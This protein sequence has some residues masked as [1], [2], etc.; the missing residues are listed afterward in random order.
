M[1]GITKTNFGSFGR[2]LLSIALAGF[3]LLGAIDQAFTQDLAGALPQEN[4]DIIGPTR[5]GTWYAGKPTLQQNEVDLVESLVFPGHI[6]AGFNDYR[7]V[8]DPIIGGAWPGIA[9]TID[10][11]IWT[12]GLIPGHLGDN[13]NLGQK[14]GADPNLEIA[15]YI[16]YYNHMAFTRD[17]S[18][19]PTMHIARFYE[20]IREV[21]EPFRFLDH[22]TVATGTTS[23]LYDKPS[24]KLSILDPDRNLPDIQFA[25][26][27]FQDP[28]NPDN[29]HE[30]YMLNVPAHRLHLCMTLFVGNDNNDGTKVECFA[31]DDGGVTF[32]IKNKLSSSIE[33]NQ[34]TSIATRNF[35]KDVTVVWLRFQDH[36]EDAAVMYASSTDY[37]E[38]Y[39]AAREVAKICPFNQTTGAAR[40][41]TNSLP[42]I[43]NSGPNDVAVYVAAR[44]DATETCFNPGKGNKPGE[45]LMSDVMLADDFDDFGE[46][47][48][49]DGNRIKDGMVRTSLNFSRIMMIRGTGSKN[50]SWGTPVAIDPQEDT[51]ESDETVRKR[52][53][54]FMPACAAAQ[55]I[56]TCSFFDTRLDKFNT[57]MQGLPAAPFVEDMVL[58]LE[59]GVPANDP[60]AKVT[61]TLLP[62][63]AYEGVPDPSL[64][65]PIKNNVPLRRTLE[66]FATSVRHGGEIR[67]YTVNKDTFY[68]TDASDPD[69]MR[70]NSVRISQFAT[71][72]K[73]GALAGVREQVEWNYCC[74][75]MFEKGKASFIGDYNGMTARS[76]RQR[77]DLEWVSNEPALDPFT[78]LFASIEPAFRAGWTS[79]HKAR[80]KI[81]YTGCDEWDES[82]QMWVSGTAGCA[83]TYTDPGT[84]LPLQGE[85]GSNDGPPLTCL[86]AYTDGKA[87]APL[88]RNQT[89]MTAAMLPDISARVVS[90]IKPADG[91]RSTFVLQLRN[92]SRSDRTVDLTLPPGE[93]VSFGADAADSILS[94]PVNVPAGSGN[95]RTA[96]DFGDSGA[97]PDLPATVILEVTDAE[98]GEILARVPLL[99]TSLETP[100]LETVQSNPDPE[101]P[102]DVPIDLLAGGE[103]YDL[104]L[105][106][107]IGVDP[108]FAILGGES[109]DLEN[110]PELFDLENLDF[111]SFDLENTL[112]FFDLENFDLENTN[113]EFDLYQAFDL[114]NIVVNL[115]NVG[116][117]PNR[118]LY[119]DLENFELENFDLENFDLENFELENFEL[120]NFELENFD[121]EN[122]ELENESVFASSIQNF[123]LENFEL[124]N[125]AP[126]DEY[127]E[128]SW[129]VDSSGN[130]TTGVDIRPIFSPDVADELATAVF[131]NEST[132]LM[133]VR[134]GY[135]N[136]TVGFANTQSCSAEIIV[137]SQILYAAILSGDQILAAEFNGTVNDPDPL[138]ADTPGFFIPPD[139]SAVITYRVI[140]PPIDINTLNKGS[141]AALFTQP[142]NL[143][144]C[145]AELPGI[146]V[147]HLCEV[148]FT[149]PD[150]TPPV[151]TVSGPS[152][153]T[154]IEDTGPYFHLSAATASDSVDG[155]VSVSVSGWNGDTTQPGTYTIT[156]T[157]TDAALNSSTTT[158]SVTV[159][160]KT[161]PVI[162]LKNP[163]VTA[164][165]AGYTYKDVAGNIY[166]ED[167]LGAT[168][169][170][171]MD[172]VVTVSSDW[173]TVADTATHG[174]S[175]TVTFTAYDNV[176]PVANKAE[177]TRLFTVTDTE[178]PVITPNLVGGLLDVS[179]E[180]GELY[181]D[182]EAIVI[183]SGSPGIVLLTTYKDENGVEISAI[184]TDIAGLYTVHYNAVDAA[185]LTAVEKTRTV[186]VTDSTGPVI[187]SPIPPTFTPTLDLAVV[188]PDANPRTFTISWPIDVK[189]LE[190]ELV[191]S[192]V[193]NGSQPPILP[194]QALSEYNS[195]T[196]IMESVF[197][198]DDFPVGT[199]SITCTATDQ[200]TNSVTTAPFY[201]T[202]EDRPIIDPGSLP[203]EPIEANSNDPVI[204]YAGS[205]T[206]LWNVT[207]SD[208]IDGA[209]AIPAVCTPATDLTFGGNTISCIATDS[210]GHSSD[211]VTFVATVV[212][213]TAPVI[214]TITTNEIV[215]A[216]NASGY[217]STG[218]LWDPVLAS[219][220]R[221]GTVETN[222]SPAS[223][224][225]FALNSGDDQTVHTVTCVARDAAGNPQDSFGNP[226]N[227]GDPG[228]PLTARTIFTVTVQDKTAPAFGGAG[229]LPLP[230]DL[231]LEAAD[232]TGYT[233]P[234]GSPLW[235]DPVAMAALDTVDGLRAATCTGVSAGGAALG[236][237]STFPLGD[238]PVSCSSTD[239]R[240]NS[241]SSAPAFNVS[242]GDNTPPAVTINVA[243]STEATDP[244]GAS[245]AFTATATDTVSGSLPSTC[246]VGGNPV[247]SGY[248][249]PLGN[250]VLT[251]TATDDAGNQ[252][253]VMT[254]VSVVDTTPPTISA[255]PLTVYTTSASATVSRADL[256][257]NITASD[258][259]DLDAVTIAC[260]IADPTVY[261]VNEPT[262]D[263]N[264]YAIECTATDSQNK[265]AT[266]T[267]RLTVAFQYDLFFV[268]PKSGKLQ[269]PAGSTLPVDFY[270][271]DNG[272][273]VD[274]SSF[275]H[276]ATWVGPY[277]DRRC[278]TEGVDFGL[279]SGEDAGWSSFR[280]S[281]SQEITQFSWHTPPIPG[282][283]NFTILP[284]GTS[285]STVCV[286]LK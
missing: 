112:I 2:R 31:S 66:Q 71:R 37:G 163:G 116:E 244:N 87:R 93:F 34:G 259:V 75:R 64:L 46:S 192:C 20:P 190:N 238:T 8:T 114:E 70:S 51:N 233:P 155:V 197:V 212:D 204:G 15:P 200:G 4:V 95:V 23:R 105:K 100:P 42:I 159:L 162:T 84:L 165:E 143:V 265:T 38:T 257:A 25:I 123:E 183:D 18:T 67:E 231:D 277:E 61:P 282:Y 256:E 194:D 166:S 146:E 276:A 188:E 170:D 181:S 118:L 267:L 191:V 139:A 249:F 145:D 266:T 29:S 24:F 3:I 213:T 90:A 211:A 172:G 189:D 247:T 17:G 179:I 106:R 214:T 195:A 169:L 150:T 77:F 164:L 55:G 286:S 88:T 207:A 219:D 186:S 101:V 283:Y 103:F 83:S 210:A 36:N 79:N 206:G 272:T 102:G 153:D 135:M 173:A 94:I 217:V 16:M 279:G 91:S 218:L 215:E 128:V 242:V 285:E 5:L 263:P 86:A 151:I 205:T 160:D 185:S 97:L 248:I 236:P 225:N 235:T 251:C 223:E 30:E 133:T 246:T 10:G 40:F 144:T 167:D 253:A 117:D 264:Y 243:L 82:L 50:L 140:N 14:G 111:S 80:G 182:A 131:A 156:Y 115:N 7:G 96:F 260:L 196:G 110:T 13:P 126:G 271:E 49:V 222:C 59:P 142:G 113:T 209:S 168:A 72:Q 35:G 258:L 270:Y 130:T 137:D 141:G 278:E 136:A 129:T 280:W 99:R 122:F 53:H 56:E 232:S 73:P 255:T 32:N 45:P 281:A 269:A 275:E 274:S 187:V 241:A 28:L 198:Y 224:S 6:A 124:E 92:G 161:P 104:I 134:R 180:A 85:D 227:P 149:P 81:F 262:A 261:L 60:N 119:F 43:V 199:S 78:D 220:V 57:L 228:F 174:W 39:G 62:A 178:P 230:A 148:D 41:R 44:N 184:D 125:S 9:T 226:L 147:N 152:P 176:L 107:E 284:P 65:P 193:V 22:L 154:V 175:F 52:S 268:L 120:E 273:R 19:V 11:S 229:T 239:A 109:F 208:G 240:G 171:E 58:H 121:L 201:V 234:T 250:S 26:P 245:V 69:Q 252:G 254:T 12:S 1:E 74:G 89:I 177:L 21:G 216:N 127:A 27:A 203:T 68:A 48:D 157:A 54:Q 138:Q 98:T 202:V 108:N 132:V 63:G 47:E 221:D 33:I 76:L 158:R 237:T